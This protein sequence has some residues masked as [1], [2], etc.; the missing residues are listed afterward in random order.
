[1]PCLLR[2][3]TGQRKRAIY[4]EKGMI[5]SGE[6]IAQGPAGGATR[7]EA[8]VRAYNVEQ[9]VGVIGGRYRTGVV[10]VRSLTGLASFSVD[11]SAAGGQ[12]LADGCSGVVRRVGGAMNI[13]RWFEAEAL[14]ADLTIHRHTT[15]GG[16]EGE[17]ESRIRDLYEDAVA[18]LVYRARRAKSGKGQTQ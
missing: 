1:M 16:S 7:S 2:R 3:K 8:T 4:T 15:M 17:I 13:R 14:R 6:T 10:W 5:P 12:T 9:A 11:G 18:I